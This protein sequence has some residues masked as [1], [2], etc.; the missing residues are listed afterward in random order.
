VIQI[1]PAISSCPY[2]GSLVSKNAAIVLLVHDLRNLLNVITMCAASIH[3][4]VPHG[5][6]DLEYAELERA[7]DHATDLVRTLLGPRH[8]ASVSRSPQDLNQIVIR[9]SETLAWIVGRAIHVTLRMSPKPLTVIADPVEIER[10]LLNLGM[11]ARDAMPDGGRL[12]IETGLGDA[13]IKTGKAIAP[14]AR[15]R[16]CDT[17]RGMTA[18]VKARIFEPFFTTKETGTGLGLNSVAFTVDQLGGTLSVD[19]EPGAGTCVAV[20]LPLADPNRLSP[21]RSET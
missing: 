9:A 20:R 6:A 8:Q 10:L 2:S 18:E 11:N 21:T 4:K 13:G 12:T 1:N 15:L 5:Q 19:S 7:V 14:L 16:V 3:E 17:G